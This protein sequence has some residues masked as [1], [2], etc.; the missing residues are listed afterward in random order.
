MECPLISVIVPVY[1]VEKYLDECIE[2][3]VNQTYRN[4]EIILVDDGSPDNCPQMCDDWAKKDERICVIHKENG[5]VSSARNAGLDVCKGE[6]IA[7]VDSDDWLEPDMYET[8]VRQI[9]DNCLIVCEYTKS[10]STD[11]DFVK[12]L[13]ETVYFKRTEFSELLSNGRINSPV[14]KLYKQNQLNNI[15]FHKDISLGEDLLFNLE[16]L[17]SS[18]ADILF[19]SEPLYHYRCEEKNTLSTKYRSDRYDN[20]LM[21]NYAVLDYCRELKLKEG[22]MKEVY[23]MQMQDALFY[24]EDLYVDEYVDDIQKILFR[25]EFRQQLIDGGMAWTGR[26]L[27]THG[28][29]RLYRTLMQM[30]N[31]LLRR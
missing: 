17:Q 12:E 7:F 29:Y 27:L 24:L 26:F 25:P 20:M 4:L 23:F 13:N 8:M 28:Q 21:L 10:N 11:A 22:Q 18:K 1:K 9:K 5:G 3:I 30:K 6:Y 31:R 15:R 16:V 19:I 14:N 2:S